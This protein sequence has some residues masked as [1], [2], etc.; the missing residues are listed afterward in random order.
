M[1]T[2]DISMIAMMIAIIIVLGM[3]PPIPLG[4]IPVPIV[5]QNL[6]VML[7]G[8]VLGAK[9]GG[10][11]IAL[12]LTLVAM[13]MPF[14]TGG[15]GGFSVFLGPTAGYL[16][17][18]FVSAILIGLGRNKFMET[19]NWGIKFLIVG[20]PGVLLV[21]LL[22]SIGLSIVTGMSLSA[23]IVSNLV[24]IP[25]DTL[26]VILVIIIAERLLKIMNRTER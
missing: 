19:K 5:L 21:D 10:L 6:G 24:F 4:F 15:S 22:G 16:I 8:I 26:I 17:G 25:G 23:S 1:K 18:W 3:I 12:F 2:K 11:A 14:L 7:A 20:I 13:G 9:K